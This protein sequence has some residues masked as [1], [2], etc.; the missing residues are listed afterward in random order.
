MEGST[1]REDDAARPTSVKIALNLYCLTLKR[2][3]DQPLS[4]G[5]AASKTGD[6]NDEKISQLHFTAPAR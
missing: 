3:C 4:K 2:E 5:M 1:V 6:A